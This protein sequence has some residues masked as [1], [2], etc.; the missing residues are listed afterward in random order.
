MSLLC[1]TI[2]QQ[3]QFPLSLL[4]VTQSSTVTVIITAILWWYR[5]IKHSTTQVKIISIFIPYF[6]INSP[7][8]KSNGCTFTKLRLYG[9]MSIMCSLSAGQACKYQEWWHHRRQPK[10]NPGIDLD[11]HFALSGERFHVESQWHYD[12]NSMVMIPASILLFSSFKRKL[13]WWEVVFM[14]LVL[15][16]SEFSYDY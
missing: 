9:Y 1:Q 12:W 4:E 11:N 3:Q 13:R 6:V 8:W 2:L 7:N 16:L 15:F 5:R 10:T 14:P